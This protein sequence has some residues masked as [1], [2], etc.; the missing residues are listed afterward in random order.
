MLLITSKALKGSRA[1]TDVVREMSFSM[2]FFSRLEKLSELL[3]SPARRIVLLAEED[4]TDPVVKCLESAGKSTPTGVIVAADRV[5]LKS[6][7]R[8]KS[9]DAILELPNVEWVGP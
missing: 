7:D 5:S 3:A 8:A 4:L 9:L 6:S 2:S 1:L